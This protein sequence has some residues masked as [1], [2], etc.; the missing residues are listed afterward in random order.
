LFLT[1]LKPNLNRD[2]DGKNDLQGADLGVGDEALGIAEAWPV[3][4]DASRGDLGL[5]LN[6]RTSR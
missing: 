4:E 1:K 6:Q 3:N 5:G 2:R